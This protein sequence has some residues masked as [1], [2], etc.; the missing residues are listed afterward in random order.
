M[1]SIEPVP[2]VR[3]PKG[4]R[5]N[6]AAREVP[7]FFFNMLENIFLNLTDDVGNRDLSPLSEVR[8]C[9]GE[10][11]GDDEVVKD[12]RGR[13]EKMEETELEAEWLDGERGLSNVSD[14]GRA[15]VKDLP[16]NATGEESGRGMTVC[17]EVGRGRATPALCGEP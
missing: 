6:A 2:A 12:E 14:G 11:R 5:G 10:E 15:R 4:S 16:P 3:L 13:A 1:A 17:P 9:R 7:S 8:D